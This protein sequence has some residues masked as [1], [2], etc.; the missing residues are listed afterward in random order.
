[1]VVKP[2]M[3]TYIDVSLQIT[4]ILEQYTNLVEPFSIDEQFVDVT[5]SQALFGKPE[6]IAEKMIAEIWLETRV[7]ARIG[8]GENKV[9]A[10]MAC[11]HFA[12]RNPLGIFW[13]KEANLEKQ[14]WPLPIE[15]MFGVGGKMA[16]HLR[17][18]GVRTIGQLAN[19]SVESLKKRWG[20]NG[21]V[22][23]M[24]ANG[25]DHSPVTTHTHDRQKAIGH[26]MTLPKD[27]EKEQEIKIILL[28][29]CE[30]VCKRA[31][32]VQ[33]MG[34]TV[35]LSLQGANYDKPTG[36][37]R[38]IKLPYHTN[39]T[40]EVYQYVCTLLKRFWD[41]KPVRRLAISLSQLE[42]DRLWQMSMLDDRDRHYRL[43]YTMDAI[44]QKYGDISIRRAVSFLKGSQSE[45]RAAKIGGHYK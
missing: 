32:S 39:I 12:K 9:L 30:E 44:K 31:R 4:H 2:H 43:G 35:S 21:E 10:K 37:H 28:E 22:L 23:W 40:M 27:Y 6:E 20:I 14:L 41:G 17:N 13:L 42:S 5:H 16:T 36:F 11:D 33:M 1:M 18:K 38:Q 34:A 8:I 29:L 3:Q 7:R 26:G 15:A 24:T 45:E 19:T 25:V